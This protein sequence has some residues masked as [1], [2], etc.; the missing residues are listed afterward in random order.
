MWHILWHILPSRH[1]Y[2]NTV[3]GSPNSSNSNR[4]REVAQNLDVDAYMVDNAGELKEEWLADKTR[5]GVSA[6]A[7][8]PDVLVQEVIARLKSLGA[9][10]V[11]ELSGTAESVVFP[12]PKGLIQPLSV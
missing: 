7:S 4:L 12:L 5:I 2:G 8:A 3:V 1:L 10:D 6:G 9:D 11:T